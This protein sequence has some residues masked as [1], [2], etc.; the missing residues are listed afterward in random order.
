MRKTE[1]RIAVRRQE[2][3]DRAAR[4]ARELALT[5]ARF[6][7]FLETSADW[8]WE[9]D[10]EQRYTYY[11]GGGLPEFGENPIGR[12]RAALLREIG[13]EPADLAEAIAAHMARGES[14]RDL[15]YSIRR[16]GGETVWVRLS[17]KPIRDEAG[18]ITGYRGSARDISDARAAEKALLGRQARYES[19][20]ANA[21][22][23]MY[24]TAL[25]GTYLEVNPAMARMHG[26]RSVEEFLRV[27]PKSTPVYA[28]PGTRERLAESAIAQG[29]LRGFECRARRRDGTLFLMSETCWPVRDAEERVIGFEGLVEDITERK[30]AEQALEQARNEALEASRAKS[31]FLAHVSHE[32]RTPLNAVIGYSDAMLQ[33][34]FG[35]LGSPRYVEY[36]RHIHDSGQ[37]LLALI[38]DLLDLSKVEAGRLELHP[39]AL[40]LAAVARATLDLVESLSEKQ[41]VPVALDLP[42]SLPLFCGDERAVK[43]ILVNLLTNALKFTPSPGRVRLALAVEEGGARLLVEDEGIGMT[44]EEIEIALLPFRQVDTPLSRR[45]EGTGL[46]LPLVKALTEAHGGGL[47]IESSPGKGTRITVRLASLEASDRVRSA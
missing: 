5:E 35:P 10:L 23:G 27:F 30:Q 1:R 41:R 7:D 21:I 22:E 3:R 12:L 16:A 26:C 19:I 31:D 45:I 28:D 34:F 25:D 13:A 18:R 36:C 8:L 20:F 4:T 2:D 15:E 6:R 14:F 42:A 39:Q 33:Q 29:Y 43:Q 44:P 47:D 9:T 37:H 38:N 17:G 32:L 40:D 24:R 46:G 11:S